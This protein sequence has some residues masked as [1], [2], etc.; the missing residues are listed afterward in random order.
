MGMPLLYT[1]SRE[2][3][4]HPCAPHTDRLAPSLRQW[5]Q[6]PDS[7]T[8][9]LQRLSNGTFAVEVLRQGWDRPRISEARALGISP[10][11]LALV[12][13]VILYGQGQAWVYARS[14]LPRSTLTGRLRSLSKLDN[15]P[16]GQLLFSDPGMRRG[17]IE[18]AR[19][20]PNNVLLPAAQRNH[21]PLWARRSCFF[22]D[23]KPLLVCETF[24]Q[25]LTDLITANS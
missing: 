1:L 15:R 9:R 8:A 14:I 5:L 10:Q 7:L 22:L 16:L 6:N 17:P 4:W 11:R 3:T 25:P 18:I 20:Q 2:P 19:Y 21:R 13:E 24:L 23:N 12:R